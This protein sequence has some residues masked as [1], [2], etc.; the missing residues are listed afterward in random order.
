MVKMLEDAG[1]M[2]TELI[3]WEGAVHAEVLLSRNRLNILSFLKIDKKLTL[4]DL[5]LN[6]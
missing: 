3:E 5:N 1:N 6:R 2:D 4:I